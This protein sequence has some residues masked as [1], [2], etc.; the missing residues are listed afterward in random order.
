MYGESTFFCDTV[1]TIGLRNAAAICQR[2]TNAIVF[3]MFKIGI[4][5]LNYLDDLAGAETKENA[6]FAYNCLGSILSKCGFEEAP[7]KAS[8]PTE[9]MIF[10]G[11]LFNTISMTVEVTEERLLEIRALIETWLGY[12][13]ASVKQIQSLLGKL[14]FVA[15]CVKPSRIF[16]SRLLQWL[17]SINKTTVCKT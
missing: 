2:V 7:E 6:Q 17:R 10:L 15:A 5:I 16:I 12:E 9:I 3:I 8:E 4:M 14:N 1:L 13:V 11:V